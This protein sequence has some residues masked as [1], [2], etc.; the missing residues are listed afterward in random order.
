MASAVGQV[1]GSPGPLTRTCLHRSSVG[2]QDVEP[3]VG[4]ES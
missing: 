2:M 1:D 3:L 4:E